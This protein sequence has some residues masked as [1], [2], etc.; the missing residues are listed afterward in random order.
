MKYRGESMK[1]VFVGLLVC[2]GLGAILGIMMG[3][4]I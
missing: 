1:D 3:M 2:G 4:A